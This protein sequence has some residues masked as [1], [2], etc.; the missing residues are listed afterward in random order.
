VQHDTYGSIILAAMPMFFDRRLPR[1]GDAR[2]FGLLESLGVQAARLAFEPDAGI[3]NTAAAV[4]VGS[5][6]SPRISAW[7]SAPRTGAILQTG[8]CHV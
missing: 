4:A 6:P 7:K 1:P 2:L 5:A 3:G 8:C